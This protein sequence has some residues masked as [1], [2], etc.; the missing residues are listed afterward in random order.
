LD[1]VGYKLGAAWLIF[2][3]GAQWLLWTS[4]KTK[5]MSIF[6][7]DLLPKHEYELALLEL[8]VEMCLFVCDR[9]L[10]DFN[11]PIAYFQVINGRINKSADI[12]IY[13]G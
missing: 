9:L 1:L 13:V 5:P 6:S 7:I 10:L 11:R 12:I 2:G 4:E 3:P 8:W